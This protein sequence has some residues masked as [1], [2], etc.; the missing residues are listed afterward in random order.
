M[1]RLARAPCDAGA[2]RRRA[3]GAG[4]KRLS[5]QADHAGDRAAA[6]RQQRH[7]GARGCRQ[8]ERGAGPAG[9]DREPRVRRKRH[10]HDP[11]RRPGTGRRLHAAARLHVDAGDRAAHV[12]QRRLRRAQGLC[13]DRVDRHGARAHCWCIRASPIAISPIW[14]PTCAPPRSRSRSARPAS[15]RSIILSALLFAQ[16]AGV[17]LQYIPYKGSRT[18]EHRSDRRLRQG[19]L[20]SDPGVAR[21][22]RG[23]AHPRAGGDV[24]QTRGRVPRPADRRGIRPAR[25]S[26]RC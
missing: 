9:R 2:G 17:K 18:A 24:A 11:R 13:A 1:L 21:R 4:A 16:Q 26:T 25:L 5:Q 10:G 7:H 15:A 19:R 3:A 14:S 12:P 6:R 23:Q 8:D 20:Q 22:H